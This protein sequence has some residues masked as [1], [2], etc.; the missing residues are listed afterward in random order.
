MTASMQLT[1]DWLRTRAS[2]TPVDMAVT[3]G[4]VNVTWS[5][6]HVRADAVAS[7]LASRGVREGDRV[8]LLLA[9]GLPFTVLTHAVP[10]LGAILVPLNTRLSARELT[11]QLEDAGVCLLVHDGSTGSLA[12]EAAAALDVRLADAAELRE[13]DAACASEARDRLERI[14]TIIYTSGT[15]GRPKGAM[16]T[17]GNHLWSAIGSALNLGLRADDQLLASLPMFHVGGLSVLVRSVIYGNPAIVQESFDPASVNAAIDGGATIVSAVANTLTRMLE[18]RGD[19]GYPLT[20]RAILLGGGPA[21]RGLL[22][23]CAVR[24]VPVV[25]TYGLTEAASQVA[26]LAPAETLRKLGSTGRPLFLTEI[27]IDGAAVP[28]DVGEILVRGA[29]VSPGYWRRPDETSETFR[30]GWLRTGDIGH[31]DGEGYLYVLDRRDDLIVSGGENVYPAEVEAVLL[32]HPEVI[33]A[34]VYGI[35]DT[36][37]GRVPLADV[38]LRPGTAL[39]VDS[40]KSYCR[41]RLANYKVPV[42]IRSVRALPRTATGKLQRRLLGAPADMLPQHRG[43]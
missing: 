27:K 1:T 10:R 36:R 26:T 41:G 11:W 29:S 15:T 37:W 33:G 21:P 12:A 31:L 23:T 24:G 9:N 42:H 16:L 13:A 28:G 20:L 39:T 32:S 17:F 19:I 18:S 2:L 30:D 3:C 40:L 43:P 38:V 14:H 25:Q 34:G 8:A 35:D 4:G 7:A 22:E 6:L 5:A